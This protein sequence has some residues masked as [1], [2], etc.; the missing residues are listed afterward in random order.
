MTTARIPPLADTGLWQAVMN[1]A[2]GRCQCRGACGKNHTKDGGR[3][4][5][6]HGGYNQHHG[7]GTVHLIAAPTEPADLLL[8]PHKA[9]TLPKARL[10]AWCPACHDAAQRAARKTLATTTPAT[11][12]DALF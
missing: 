10:S 2:A 9:A 6:E 5:R 3:C 7:G 11:E 8:P 1:A 4:P 12:P